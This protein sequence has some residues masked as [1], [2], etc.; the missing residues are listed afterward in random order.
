MYGDTGYVVP[1]GGGTIT[2]FSFQVRTADTPVDFLVL[3]PTVTAGSYT[4]VGKTGVQTFTGTGVETFPA[5]V[6]VQGGDILGFWFNGE[7][8]NNCAHAGSGENLVFSTG[9]DDPSTGD[10]VSLFA[11]PG[12]ADLN[13]SANLVPPPLPTSKDQCKKGGWKSFGGQFKNQGDCVSF[14]ATGGKN[15]PS[16]S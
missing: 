2:S 11:S 5:S 3:R 6:R 12:G 4:V 1:G 8:L 13:E 16:G 15:Q 7:N 10:T 9:Q 14:V